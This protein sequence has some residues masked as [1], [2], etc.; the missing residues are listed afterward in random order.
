MQEAAVA[1]LADAP[2]VPDQGRCE[3]VAE[4]SAG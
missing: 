2:G 4:R 3:E 1:G